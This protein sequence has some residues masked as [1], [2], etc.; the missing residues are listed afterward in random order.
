MKYKITKEQLDLLTGGL[1]DN[2]TVE[3]IAKNMVFQLKK[4]ILN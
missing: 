4:L 3:Y 2:K 1:S